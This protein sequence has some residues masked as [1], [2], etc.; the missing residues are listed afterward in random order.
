[1][2]TFQSNVT[3]LAKWGGSHAGPLGLLRKM[4]VFGLEKTGGYPPAFHY[5]KGGYRGK[6]DR[7]FS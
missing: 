6:Q 3:F 7:V 2:L 4:D 1:M 5:L